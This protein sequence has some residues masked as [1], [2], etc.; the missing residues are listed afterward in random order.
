MAMYLPAPMP[1]AV[2][3]QTQPWITLCTWATIGSFSPTPNS[4]RIGI[5]VGPNASK[6]SCD[7]QMS[8]TWISPFDSSATW[9]VRPLGAPAPAASSCL[10]ALSY[11]S[12]VNPSCTK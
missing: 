12:C 11:L 4:V 1:A 10:I 5:R 6:S 7:S 9:K 2:D 8:K 3:G